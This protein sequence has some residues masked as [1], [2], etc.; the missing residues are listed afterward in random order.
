M[1]VEGAATGRGWTG[2]GSGMGMILT[3]LGFESKRVKT[4]RNP[5]SRNTRGAIRHP[6]PVRGTT[7]R[8][9]ALPGISAHRRNR[10]SRP[11]PK[12]RFPSAGAN[13]PTKPHSPVHEPA[14]THTRPRSPRGHTTSATGSEKPAT[15]AGWGFQH[16]EMEM[17]IAS[18]WM[19][20]AF[21]GYDGWGQCP[22]GLEPLQPG[23]QIR[24]RFIPIVPGGCR[25]RRLEFLNNR[26]HAR[27][28]AQCGLLGE[29]Q[30]REVFA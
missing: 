17:P 4:V 1:G 8:F 27:I 26:C 20:S 10:D 24:T 21:R 11:P 15:W 12:P 14:R 3:V 18:A 19:Q 7:G 28:F 13:P 23:E 6:T 5:R 2:D 16:H 30:P 25:P 29:R 9:G 22:R